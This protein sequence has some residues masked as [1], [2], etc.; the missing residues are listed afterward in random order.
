MP[1]LTE[2]EDFW[3][4]AYYRHGAPPELE[5]PFPLFGPLIIVKIA[6]NLNVRGTHQNAKPSSLLSRLP[7]ALPDLVTDYK[8]PVANRPNLHPTPPKSQPNPPYANQLDIR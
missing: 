4:R 2:L 7:H 5:S 3:A 8:S 6:R 1:L